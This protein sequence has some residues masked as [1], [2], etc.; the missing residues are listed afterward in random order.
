VTGS[1]R[2]EF[3]PRRGSTRAEPGDVALGLEAGRDGLLY[4]PDTAEPGAPVMVLLHGAGG[5]GRRELRAV[6]AAADR[7]G[8]VVVA[9]DSRGPTW[10]VI[11]EGGFG[12]D[13]AFIDRA[14]DAAVGRCDADFG[15]L[16]AAGISD[17]ASY[18]LSIGLSNGELFEAI[19]AFS[20]GFVSPGPLVGRPRVFVSHGIDDR[21]LPI[22]ACSRMIVPVLRNAGYDVTYREFDGGH[23]LPPAVADE[24]VGWWVSGPPPPTTPSPTP[25]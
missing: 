2:L 15:R 12:A 6:V 16:A 10:D 9:P 3:L 24:A 14:L 17:G 19:L 4:V 5:T 25:S 11:V 13:P 18:A 8:A 1:A 22:D 21:I 23:T 7:Y 20:P